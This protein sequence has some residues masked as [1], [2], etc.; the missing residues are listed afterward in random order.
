MDV[1]L[2]FPIVFISL[3]LIKQKNNTLRFRITNYWHVT[4]YHLV[5]G[6]QRSRRKRFHHANL[7]GFIFQK[8]TIPRGLLVFPRFFSLNFANQTGTLELHWKH[9]RHVENCKTAGLQACR[10]YGP[11]DRFRGKFLVLR[12]TMCRWYSRAAKELTFRISTNVLWHSE[13]RASW[14]I[15]ITKTNRCTIS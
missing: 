8:S 6:L 7:H 10:P 15:P 2:H 13:D 1:C 4:P 12:L 11:G 3:C 14:Y 9:N 5:Q